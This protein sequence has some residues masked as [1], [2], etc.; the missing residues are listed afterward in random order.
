MLPGTR[1]LTLAQ[2]FRS[3]A[4]P[5]NLLS[6]KCNT[7]FYSFVFTKNTALKPNR[8]FLFPL[9]FERCPTGGP[10]A[11]RWP[12]VCVPRHGGESAVY[13]TVTVEAP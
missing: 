2:C 6:Q 4:L 9:P 12:A 7:A 10:R 13:F 3:F 5:L 1:R 8:P 11:G